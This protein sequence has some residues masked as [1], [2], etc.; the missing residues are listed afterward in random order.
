MTGVMVQRKLSILQMYF[1]T[2]SDR[3][4]ALFRF[5]TQKERTRITFFISGFIFMSVLSTERI[6]F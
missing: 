6:V 4:W 2:S 1:E 5:Y 3:I